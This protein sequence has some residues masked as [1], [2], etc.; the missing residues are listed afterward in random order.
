MPP[1]QTCSASGQLLKNDRHP[2]NLPA[3]VQ[4]AIVPGLCNNEAAMSI[5]TVSGAV[6]ITDVAILY[7]HQA[8]QNGIQATVD[9]E[10]YDG[11]TAL[12]NGKYTLGPQVFKLSSVAAPLTVQSTGM[13]TFT[14]PFPVRIASGKAVV[15]FRMLQNRAP[16]SCAAGYSAN[17]VTDAGPGCPLGINVL[18]A[19]GHGPVDPNRYTGFG[20]PLCSGFIKYFTGRWMIRACAEPEA[21]VTWTGQPTPGGVVSLQFNA[22]GQAGYDYVA[23]LS[24][25]T[26][27]TL[28][29]PWGTIQLAGTPTFFCF[30][31]PCRA[32]LFGGEGQLGPTGVATGQLFIPNLPI[33]VGSGLTF[34]AAVV[35]LQLPSY[36]FL[37]AS[38]PSAP[39]VIN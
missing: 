3:S 13:N 26:Q 9:V 15:G 17:F 36:N 2:A 25:A 16:G 19:I 39:I 18:D 21:S 10:I 35:T 34:Y 27:P 37:G 7:A 12:L 1:A 20:V 32:L 31:G 8:S 6:R 22:P 24:E 11:A 29:T 28:P 5:F 14:L 4:I 38:P 30:L 33:L 23:F